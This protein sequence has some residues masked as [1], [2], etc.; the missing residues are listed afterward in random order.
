VVDDGDPDSSS[1]PALVASNSTSYA[2]PEVIEGFVIDSDIEPPKRY[3]HFGKRRRSFTEELFRCQ[4][5]DKISRSDLVCN[6]LLWRNRPEE[7]RKHL[8]QHLGEQEV[9]R[10]TD[11]QVTNWYVEAKHIMLTEIPEDSDFSGDDNLEDF[12][13][14]DEE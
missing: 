2:A 9:R 6:A 11:D 7:L 12:D 10:M 5:V 3:A 13:E 14:E 1:K 4:Y 8:L